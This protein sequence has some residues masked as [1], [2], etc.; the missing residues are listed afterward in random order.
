MGERF[1]SSLNMEKKK[2]RLWQINNKEQFMLLDINEQ[3]KE[4]G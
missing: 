4:E 3:S 2:Q 1:I